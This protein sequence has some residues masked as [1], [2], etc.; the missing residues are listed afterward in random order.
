MPSMVALKAEIAEALD[1]MSK[2]QKLAEHKALT[3][4]YSESQMATAVEEE[5]WD[6]F[7]EDIGA[8]KD[9]FF[10]L[11]DFPLEYDSAPFRVRNNRRSSRR[12]FH[13]DSM[14]ASTRK[15]LTASRK[16]LTASRP[17]RSQRLQRKSEHTAEVDESF[18]LRSNTL[19]DF[20]N[21]ASS[22]PVAANAASSRGLKPTIS[23]A[24]ATE[25]HDVIFEDCCQGTES[26][27]FGNVSKTA[28]IVHPDFES[29]T[30]EDRT[31]VKAPEQLFTWML[32]NIPC[33]LYQYELIRIMNTIG[34]RGKFNFFFTPVDAKKNAMRRNH[35]NRN[36]ANNKGYAFINLK[37]KEDSDFLFKLCH[38]RNFWGK[39]SAT[40]S[41]KKC[42]IVP[43]TNQGFLENIRYF[44]YQILDNSLVTAYSRDMK[45]FHGGATSS[46]SL[47]QSAFH[48]ALGTEANSP[49]ESPRVNDGKMCV[50]FNE[51]NKHPTASHNLG[52]YPVE[53]DFGADSKPINAEEFRPSEVV[54]ESR[55]AMMANKRKKIVEAMQMPYFVYAEHLFENAEQFVRWTCGEH[56]FDL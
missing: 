31:A 18:C 56:N 23:L 3:R 39:Y 24:P 47:N 19:R 49:V 53:Y 25:M 12:S 50:N 7:E 20:G 29:D 30:E 9:A 41:K 34:L 43:S 55:A 14:R 46:R 40:N 35:K 26:K 17:L 15:S 6:Q 52:N 36:N 2:S 1:D 33:K 37:Q 10:V 48:T 54:F 13:R 21:L 32:R 45:N 44:K 4:V 8:R 38:D 11:D 42:Q 28:Q 22:Q 16:S 27:D 51:G 5:R